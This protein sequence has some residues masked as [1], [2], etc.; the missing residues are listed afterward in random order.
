MRLHGQESTF[1]GV[2]Y[3][4]ERLNSR[5]GAGLTPGVQRGAIRFPGP[6]PELPELR[7]SSAGSSGVNQDRVYWRTAMDTFRT[8]LAGPLEPRPVHVDESSRH[9][10]ASA[11]DCRP[12]PE[13][14]ASLRVCAGNRNR[15]VPERRRVAAQRWLNATPPN[16]RSQWAKAMQ[17]YHWSTDPESAVG[18]T[19]D[20]LRPVL[21]KEFPDVRRRVRALFAW[22]GSGAGP[23]SGYPGYED[24]PRRLLFDYQ[25]GDL[26]SA[27]QA[28]PLTAPEMTRNGERSGPTQEGSVG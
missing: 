20:A 5:R 1:A 12:A 23:W 3:V 19:A 8:C 17:D 18:T 4:A 9:H 28:A 6:L 24:V 10:S 22:F 25:P 14:M 13:K 7:Q 26:I 16:M 2:L 27:L 21:T 15:V 11:G